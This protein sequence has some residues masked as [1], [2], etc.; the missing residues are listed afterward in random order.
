VPEASRIWLA[1]F[2]PGVPAMGE[3]ANTPD[4]Y[5]RDIA[6][7]VLDLLGIDY[8]EYKGAK[9]KPLTRSWGGPPGPRADPLVGSNAT[10]AVR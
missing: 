7:T 6:P 1:F 3:A 4:A 2:G 5:Q 8:T 9:G 10:A